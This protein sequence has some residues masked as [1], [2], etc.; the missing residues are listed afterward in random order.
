MLI[1]KRG[2]LYVLPPAA[3]ACEQLAQ[4][5][6]SNFL[7]ELLRQHE[8]LKEVSGIGGVLLIVRIRHMNTS[9]DGS[10]TESR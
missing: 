10:G 1:D 3:A 2:R 6:D 5:M 9:S 7:A 8:R 4:P